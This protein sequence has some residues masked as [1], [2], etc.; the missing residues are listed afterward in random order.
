VIGDVRI[1]G[2]ELE[3]STL[4]EAGTTGFQ[5]SALRRG[6]WVDLH[7]GV[8]PAL[9][10]AAQ[11][12]V[13]RLQAS[14]LRT[15]TIR[16]VEHEAGVPGLT[17]YEGTPRTTSGAAT[18]TGSNFSVTANALTGPADMASDAAPS[19][20]ARRKAAGDE[21]TGVFAL[22]AEEGLMR[23][24][25][26]EIAAALALPVE[27]VATSVAAGSLSITTYGNP[28]AWTQV[29]GTEDAIAFTARRRTS[30]YG[31][32]RPYE[33][34]L[35]AGVELAAVDRALADTAT[36]TGTQR[37]VHEVDTFAAL[38]VSPDPTEEFWFQAAIGNHSSFQDYNA[39]VVLNDVDGEAG[40]FEFA[41]YAA[42]GLSSDSPLTLTMTLNGQPGE[43]HQVTSTGLGVVTFALPAGSLLPG[44]NTIRI[45]A[46]STAAAGT[47]F[48]YVD[49]YTLTFGA[50]L[51]FADAGRFQ[52]LS[53]GALAFELDAAVGTP[54]F[55]VDA[56][57]D[58]VIT[59][60]RTDI[61]GTRARFTFDAQA[62][63]EYFVATEGGLNAP[64]ALRARSEQHF[65][66]SSRAADYV[67]IAPA[68]LFDAATALATR[69][70]TQG[71]TTA[72][73]DV[74]DIYDAF[75][76]GDHNPYAIREFFRV[77]HEN[78][79]TAPR[80]AL[81]LGDGNIDYR[82]AGVHGSGSIPPMLVRT[83]RGAFASDMLLGDTNGDGRPEVAIGRVPAHTVAE[84]DAFV[85]RVVTYESGDLDAFTRHALLVSGTNRG[86]D[87]TRYV[88]TLAGQLDERVNAERLDRAALTLADARTQLIGAINDGSFWFHYQGHG[89]SSQLDDD[90]LLTMA[91]VAGLT[92][93]NALTIFTGMSCSTSRFEIPGMDSISEL[94][95]SG[96]PGGA[97]AL[98]GPSGPGY[99][100]E[101]GNIAE[102]FQRHLLTGDNL[103]EGRM[104][105]VVMGLWERGA[106]GA[107]A[108]RDQLSIYLLLG[109]PATV[110]PDRTELAPPP[111]V[112]DPPEED[113]GVTV[114]VM[115]GG[116]VV[117]V[118]AGRDDAGRPIVPGPGPVTPPGGALGGGSCTV[119]AASGADTT[120]GLVLLLGLLAGLGRRA[121]RRAR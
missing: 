33:L 98:Y 92:N 105:D 109:D 118:D 61:D 21:P 46:T 70:Q 3:W 117:R 90:G 85:Q 76:H 24:T 55:L 34:R 79:S 49:R 43:A 35:N 116:G 17:I 102:A 97:I 29:D 11:G 28:V 56:T 7:E 99:T 37:I 19:P 87:F 101:S 89:A 13:Y 12:A 23:V 26:A 50:P 88:D 2:G 72:V 18:L 95:L 119:S 9:P 25:Y 65:E 121:R 112:V 114:P 106:N 110:L 22:A 1:V 20:A 40:T 38:A 94:M 80:Y 75:G 45:R 39:T 77:A 48:A 74:Q 78:W 73:V 81:L 14:G 108:S 31:G 30:V 8:L 68:A 53:N 52:A 44:P 100:Y 32:T 10:N 59:A 107:N 67:V 103:A 6:Q 86:E 27:T 82:G 71:L 111:V 51:E 63:H 41:Y 54:T 60:T 47:A 120:G 96:S 66:D 36:G 58:R 83:D 84:A 64:S 4:S 69:R 16:I 115:D 113:A 93:S 62:G 5:V 91:D 42:P 57:L 15:A 104:G